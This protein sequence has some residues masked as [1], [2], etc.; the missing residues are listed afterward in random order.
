MRSTLTRTL[1]AGMASLLL[2]GLTGCATVGPDYAAPAATLP[3]NYPHASNDRS[4]E[5]RPVALE[6]WWQGFDDPLLTR[7]VESALTQNLDLEAAM[8]RVDQARALVQRSTAR[9]MPEG[10]FSADLAAERQSLQSPIGAIA[11]HLPGYRRDV[12]L[13]DTGL[14]ASW[15]ADLF[16]KLRRGRDQALADA[17]ATEAE[18]LGVRVSVA[19]EVADAYF[20]LRRAQ[21]RLALA[22][23]QLQIDR[24]LLDLIDDRFSQGL[25]TRRE[26]AEAHARVAQ[27]RASMPALRGEIDLES[28]RLDV[29]MGSP[30]G[31][32][33]AELAGAAPGVTRLP[34]LP[35]RL[36]PTD[37]LTRRPDVIAAERRLA[38]TSARIGVATA[39]YYPQW[40]LSG[41]LGF[42]SLNTS[43]L[44]SATFQPQALIGLRWR[45]FDF[46][47][48]DAE[49]AEAKGANAEALARYRNTMLKATEDVERALITQ[50]ALEAERGD[51]SEEV[52]A[53]LQA[54][55]S[56]EEA[57]RGGAASLIEVLEQDRQLFAARDRL[58]LVQSDSA[59]ALVDT[60]RALGGGW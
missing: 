55:D 42:E 13:H 3:V 52:A 19:A 58:E 15:E 33:A 57:F 12:V 36:T 22:E 34:G 18:Q 27:V 4:A 6:V 8:A 59:R 1:M 31:T 16:G 17:Q 24:Q 23:E 51:L 46:G 14:G 5:T 54:R 35:A 37:L 29:L 21:R 30:P 41:L 26:Q 32:H 9:Q 11:Q 10:N 45:L 7:L 40:S 38:A 20:K 53:D 50:S 25:G 60:F 43:Q 56:S 48:V 28:N 44:S 2:S 39:D 47:R 49:V